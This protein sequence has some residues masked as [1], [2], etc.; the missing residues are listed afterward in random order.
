MYIYYVD[1]VA[2]DMLLMQNKTTYSSIASHDDL[3]MAL[4]SHDEDINHEAKKDRTESFSSIT[5]HDNRPLDVIA[6]LGNDYFVID[7]S[8]SVKVKGINDKIELTEI[9][10][11]II[12]ND[13]K[14]N[15]FLNA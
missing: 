8:L 5:S 2:V 11:Q 13:K 12:K 4:I 6:F 10:H 3:S 1:D 9:E 7:D 15:S 14:L